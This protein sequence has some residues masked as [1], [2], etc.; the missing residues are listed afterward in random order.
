[1]SLIICYKLYF[2]I[3]VG[4]TA[5]AVVH[6]GLNYSFQ[7]LINLYNSICD[8]CCNVKIL[9]IMPGEKTICKIFLQKTVKHVRSVFILCAW[10]LYFLTEL[11]YNLSKLVKYS[12]Y[13]NILQS[14]YVKVGKY[15]V[16]SGKRYV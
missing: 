13:V 16:R 2:V 8:V 15:N 6:I 1:M 4:V 5:A 9:L 11:C 10:K 7:K 3:S 12:I 14:I